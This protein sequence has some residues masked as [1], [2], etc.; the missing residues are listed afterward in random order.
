MPYTVQSRI[1][2]AEVPS[3]AG[4]LR[5]LSYAG[6][7]AVILVV[8]LLYNQVALDLFSDWWTQPNLSQGLLI[9]PFALYIAYLRRNTTL[10]LPIAP[11]C[12]GLIVIGS[13]C[14]LY[15]LGI[16]AAEFFILRLSLLL[17]LT[18]CVW[19]FWG[20]ERLRTLLFPLVLLASAIPLP[21]IVYNTLAAPLQ[22]L[23]SDMATSL[24]QM[25]GVTVYQDGN[26]LTLAHMTLGVEEACSGLNS[27]SAML[28]GGVLVGFILC[29]KSAS[30]I[31]IVLAA[32]PIA[33][34]ANIVRVT[35]TAVLADYD[36]KF[37]RGFYHALS[38]W[39][40]FL[41]GFAALFAIAQVLSKME[42]RFS[43]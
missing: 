31:L 41:I 22:L 8:V 3:R 28:A 42:R 1:G 35:G 21:A 24:A 32:V 18:G 29:R 40:I 17:L 16:A 43:C 36:E 15:V 20:R 37:A 6:L 9:V 33:I 39:L 13:A 19:T 34:C 7:L 4:S 23:A 30:R 14:F 10:Q 2:P 26:I 12:R 27:L 25:L 38:G 11:D 5:L